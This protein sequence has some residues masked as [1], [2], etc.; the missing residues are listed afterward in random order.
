MSQLSQVCRIV[1]TDVSD[2]SDVSNV[3]DVSDFQMSQMSQMSQV[4]QVYQMSQMSQV[5]QVSRMSRMSQ[6]S[7]IELFWTAKNHKIET[8]RKYP[9]A[10][11]LFLGISFHESSTRIQRIMA[12]MGLKKK[13]QRI[14]KGWECDD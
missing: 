9:E 14:M 5:S 3:S 10:R 6:M 1:L 11:M 8:T 12:Q 7:P 13:N 4:S 2:V